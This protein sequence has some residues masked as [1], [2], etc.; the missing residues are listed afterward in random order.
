MSAK[1]PVSVPSLAFDEQFR[2]D[3]IRIICGTDEAGR[4]P[5]AGPVVA[6]ACIL[7]DGYMPEGLND[8]KKLT[9]KKREALYD[10][11]A[12]DAV[13]FCVASASP[14]EIDEYNI[15]NASLLAMRRAIEGLGIRPDLSIA[16]FRGDLTNR[17][18]WADGPTKM[19][20]VLFTIDTAT[21]LCKNVERV[22]LT[23]ENSSQR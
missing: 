21:G 2:T 15:L 20:A 12:R 7:P 23:D 4:G 18:Q 14:A 8:S 3:G 10:I 5:L 19:E 9:E 16:K 17:Y 11:I 6:A 13:A 22:D 1:T